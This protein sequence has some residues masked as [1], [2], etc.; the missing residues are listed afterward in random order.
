MSENTRL[1]RMVD[2]PTPLA[3]LETWEQF[4]KE[5]QGSPDNMALRQELIADAQWTI[6]WIKAGRPQI[7]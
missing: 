6:E 5:L 3:S 4:L 7:H 1:I 2:P